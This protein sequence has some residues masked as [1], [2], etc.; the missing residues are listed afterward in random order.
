MTTLRIEHRVHDYEAWKATF[1]RDP[2]D[3]RGSGVRRYTIARPLDAPSSVV[4]DLEFD[5][6][7]AAEAMLGRLRELWTTP[8]A[9]RA[10]AGTPTTRLIE[11][12]EERRF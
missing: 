11:R 3:R 5:D 4:I 7:A 12:V 1:D 10:L 9:V 2:L 8:T 6:R